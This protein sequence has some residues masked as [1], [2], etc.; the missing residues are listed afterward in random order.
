[1]RADFLAARAEIDEHAPDLLVA[2][3]RL[4]DFNGLHLAI[5][6]RGRGAHTQAIVIGPPDSVL[7]AEACR[8][9]ISYLTSPLDEDMFAVTARRL[10]RQAE[11]PPSSA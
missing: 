11:T 3:V 7:E 2:E 10:L 4:G 9:E 1:V 6:A 8:Q 5:R